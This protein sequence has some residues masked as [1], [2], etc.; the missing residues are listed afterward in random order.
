MQRG[1]LI[2]IMYKNGKKYIKC[3]DCGEY[4]E[5]NKNNFY[6]D[7]TSIGY[8]RVCKACKKKYYI[9]NRAKRLAYQNEYNREKKC[10]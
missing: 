4:K 8:K 7:N 3:K 6:K 2:D 9:Q 1:L 5:L 10:L